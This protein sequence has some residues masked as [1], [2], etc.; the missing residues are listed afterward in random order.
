M[1]NGK[2]LKRRL[3]VALCSVLASACCVHTR[4]FRATD[5][6]ILPASVASMEYA[7]IGGMRQR[8]W[9]RGQDRNAP[10]LIL[11][12]AGPGVS[13]AALFRHFNADLERHFLVVYW[14]QRGAGRSFAADIPPQS[15]T[16]T[17]FLRD[18]DEVVQLVRGRFDKDRV[19][20][21][22]HSW[23][24]V[25][26]TL[27]AH[28]HPEKIAAY[29]GVGQIADLEESARL[30][31][32]YAL[33]QAEQRGDGAAARDLRAIGPRPSSAD[34][35]LALLGWVERF[36]GSFHGDLSM[37]DLIRT[38]IM[39]DE[40]NLADLWRLR[41][42]SRF[43]M[44]HLWPELSQ[45]SLTGYRSFAVPIFF[46]LGRHDWQMPATVA[47][48]YFDRID[49]PCKRLVWFEHSGHYPPF[50]EP[51]KFERVLVDEVLPLALTG[52]RTCPLMDEGP[53]QR[54]Q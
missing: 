40:T 20:L 35:M 47:A 18:L 51:R 53:R 42:G 21:V 11:L 31:Y 49:A 45:L 37:G 5:G 10:A 1:E 22:G 13:E 50:E 28:D 8:L 3:V 38:V 12:H 39:S 6:K 24:T 52:A 46:L 23:G 7:T 19:V 25:L 44:E 43:S 14:E 16:I 27:Y 32:E 36:G 26:G 54:G 48:R 15:M 29:V 30:S 17:Q 41:Q 33:A 34:A 9:F 2:P 4:P